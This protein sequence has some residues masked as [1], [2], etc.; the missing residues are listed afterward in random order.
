MNRLRGHKERNEFSKSTESM[1]YSAKLQN[2]NNVKNNVNAT[3]REKSS[4]AAPVSV[5]AKIEAGENVN[6]ASIKDKSNLQR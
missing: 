1:T 5:T 2:Y 4:S 6:V 3:E